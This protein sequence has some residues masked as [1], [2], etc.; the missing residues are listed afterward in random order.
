MFF[1]KIRLRGYDEMEQQLKEISGH[2]I[3]TEK[4]CP[5][6]LKNAGKKLLTSEVVAGITTAIKGYA[7]WSYGDMLPDLPQKNA[8]A[9]I[10]LMFGLSGCNLI[11]AIVESK[12]DAEKAKTFFR[13][14]VLSKRP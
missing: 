8:R 5:L 7:T 6:L 3:F 14:N 9:L 13:E 12:S 11:D 2:K 4:F 1:R 10:N